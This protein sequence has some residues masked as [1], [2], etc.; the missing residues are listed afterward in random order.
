[1]RRLLITA[2]SFVFPEMLYGQSKTDSLSLAYTQACY[3]GVVQTQAVLPDVPQRDTL[4]KR[5]YLSC[6]GSLIRMRRT[7][8]LAE[9]PS[10]AELGCGYAAG[11]MFAKYGFGTSEIKPPSPR[12]LRAVVACLDALKP[13]G[14]I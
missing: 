12:L 7:G 6:D 11:S 10:M 13:Q 1:M 3:T 14:I 8:Q 4:L 5:G 2:A 9:E